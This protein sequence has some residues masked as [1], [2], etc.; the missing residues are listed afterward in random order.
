MRQRLWTPRGRQ[1]NRTIDVRDPIK[2]DEPVRMLNGH[3]G[4][5]YG[6]TTLA[7]ANDQPRVA[8]RSN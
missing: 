1:D 2:H 5:V 7:E 4:D 8:A 6:V 3:S